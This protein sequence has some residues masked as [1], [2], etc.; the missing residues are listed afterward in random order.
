MFKLNFFFCFWYF[1]A[2]FRLQKASFQKLFH[3][4]GLGR[5]PVISAQHTVFTLIHCTQSRI[6]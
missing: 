3:V 2:S 1:S 6:F 5:H 4:K